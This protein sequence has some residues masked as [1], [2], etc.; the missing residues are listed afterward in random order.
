MLEV[1]GMGY[2]EYARELL[3]T[4]AYDTPDNYP[5]RF[6]DRLLW[7]NNIWYRARI[8]A[9]ICSG[10]R[11]ARRGLWNRE[12]WTGLAYRVFETVEACGGKIHIRG[13]H[14]LAKVKGAV[15]C[16]ANHMS[17]LE[18]MLLPAQTLLS[19][20]TTY[21][22]KTNL[23]RYPI[24]GRVMR[25]IDPVAVGR[26]NPREDFKAVLQGGVERLEQGKAMIIFPQ[27]T[28]TVEFNPETFNSLGVKLARK[29]GV[30]VVPVALKTDFH[31]VGKV[32][33]DIGRVDRHKPLH[34]EYGEPMTVERNEREVH[35]R[36]VQF[37]SDCLR[38][39]GGKVADS[40]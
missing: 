5:R 6:F 38:K 30:P 12:S 13:Y 35:E 40:C 14:N 22:V 20:H 29:A 34:F 2:T 21:V 27:S 24:F 18:T 37:I 4:G 23:L 33:K 28:R 31:A 26:K 9:V 15:V 10:R 25:A 32:V 36:V 11:Y 1:S 3:E 17:I 7:W 19:H 8:G 16:L 39:W